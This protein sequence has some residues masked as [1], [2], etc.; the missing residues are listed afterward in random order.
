LPACLLGQG[1][2]SAREL[3]EGLA[4]TGYFLANRL[5]PEL[6]KQALPEARQR[7]V[8]LLARQSASP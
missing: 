8:D 5:A 3:A 2:A 4:L 1:P 6:G 7:L